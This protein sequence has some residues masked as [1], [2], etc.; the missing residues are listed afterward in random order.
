MGD[1][2][3]N[4][5][6]A[7]L[8]ALFGSTS[9]LGVNAFWVEMSVH[10]QTLPEGWNLGSIL[11]IIIQISSIPAIL[12]TLL[13]QK[14]K[15]TMSTAPIIVS[16][17]LLVSIVIIFVGI[18]NDVTV[19]IAGSQRSIVVYIG[20]F[21]VGVVSILSDVLFIPYIK[22][23]AGLYFNAFFVG[24]GMSAL[25][26]SIFSIIQGARSYECILIN[27]TDPPH[28]EPRFISPRFGVTTFY[29]LTFLWYLIGLIAF[30]II[31]YFRDSIHRLWPKRY[32]WNVKNDI[33]VPIVVGESDKTWNGRI[34]VLLLCMIATVYGCISVLMPS[35]QSFVVLPYS[36]VR[37]CL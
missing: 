22:N 4:P 26:P 31:H 6:L 28:L 19:H 1:E 20:M 27:S 21:F 36:P 2:C 25:V 32:T 17:L 5:L 3:F 13:D 8:V 35:I 16:S 11:T 24:L 33:V 7:V 14:G 29:I 18:F 12:Y 37:R 34:D 15:V 23:M 9:W 30:I 10:T